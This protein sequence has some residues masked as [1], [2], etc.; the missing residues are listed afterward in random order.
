M[1][2][3]IRSSRRIIWPD[4]PAHLGELA[5]DRERLGADALADG[6]LDP[7]GQRRLEVPRQL[8]EAL[9]ALA[10]PL[11]RRL[12]RARLGAALGGGAEPFPGALD[13]VVVHRRRQ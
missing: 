12:D 9:D 8:G 4:E 6:L 2:P 5:R 11:E 3:S 7:C 10:R 1:S 13:R